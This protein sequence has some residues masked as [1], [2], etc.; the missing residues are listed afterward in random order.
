RKESTEARGIAAQRT[1]RRVPPDA[2]ALALAAAVVHAAWN[3]A[4]ADAEQTR[5]ATAV[6]LLAGA[7]VFAPVAALTW[8]V[9]AAAAPHRADL[10][11]AFGVAVTIATYTLID[12]RGLEHAGPLPYLELELLGAA[13]L[14]AG[15]LL[16]RGAGPE[17]RS[18]ASPRAVATGVGMFASYGLT[19]AA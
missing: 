9:D 2:L 15:S 1:L 19:L 10:A 8:D 6:A 5:A 3:V 14:Y 7:V 12:K 18:A 17:L 4:L 11:L 16:A 13:L